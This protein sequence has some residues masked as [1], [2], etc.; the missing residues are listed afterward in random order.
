MPY[1]SRTLQDLHLPCSTVWNFLVGF[2]HTPLYSTSLTP[3][4]RYHS[5]FSTQYANGVVGSIVI[6]GPASLPY[7]IDLGAFPISDWYL[8]AAEQI[9]ERVQSTTN[10]IVPGAPGAPPQSDNILFNGSNINPNGAGGHYYKVTLTPGKRHLLRLINPS[11]ENEFSVSLVGHDMTVI[12]TDF[13][14]VNAFTTSSVYLGIG[15]R[16]SVTIDASQA[17]GNYWF[18][19]TFSGTGGCGSSV[20][21]HPAAIFSYTGAP[22]ANPTNP[23]TAPPDSLCADNTNFTPIVSRTA[24]LTNFSPTNDNLPVTLVTD[25]QLSK[26]FWEVNGSAI[27]VQWNKPTLQYVLNG[28]TNFPASENLI[29]V[30]Q[31]NIVSAHMIHISQPSGILTIS[32]SGAYGWSKT[33]RLFR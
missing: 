8:G 33:F 23:G 20:N 13:V 10:P 27:Q 28:Q 2:Y 21:P 26:V 19:V 1:S 7:D 3:I 11:V 29:Q 16:Y 15:Q 14:P 25:T 24:P 17:V 12:E 6:N 18:N 30:P 4:S 31:S 32:L 22:N 5:H 9:E